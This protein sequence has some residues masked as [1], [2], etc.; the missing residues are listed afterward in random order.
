M[1]I[2]RKDEG[3]KMIL[4]FE[5]GDNRKFQQC[6]KEW[7]FISEQAMIRFW[8]SV[9]LSSED[10]KIIGYTKDGSIQKF[11]PADELLTIK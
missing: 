1:S 6:L 9:M 10:K 5:D 3:D 2:N 4:T 7:N 11:A 8:L